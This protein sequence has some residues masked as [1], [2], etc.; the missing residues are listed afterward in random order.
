MIPNKN[1]IQIS[2]DRVHQIENMFLVIV[3]CRL[4]LILISP[5]IR[6]IIM[7]RRRFIIRNLKFSGIRSITMWINVWS[8]ARRGSRTLLKK[9]YKVLWVLLE[10]DP[11]LN[12]KT[13]SG[14]YSKRLLTV[15]LASKILWIKWR[16]T[17]KHWVKESHAPSIN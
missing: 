12:E 7:G 13:E 6:A 1:S 3:L 5:T 11:P 8:W 10:E 2:E 17:K 9:Q 4:L 16:K 15:Y 14:K